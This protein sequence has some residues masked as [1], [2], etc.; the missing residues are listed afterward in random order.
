MG[1][2]EAVGLSDVNPLQQMRVAGGVWAT[3]RRL[4]ANTLVDAR[5]LA[6]RASASSIVPNVVVARKVLVRLDPDEVS[7]CGVVVAGNPVA[8]RHGDT[9]AQPVVQRTCGVDQL[10]GAQR[11]DSSMRGGSVT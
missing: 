3:V 9:A 7:P 5:T 1:L 11:H 8:K 6:M 2:K 4:A 10:R